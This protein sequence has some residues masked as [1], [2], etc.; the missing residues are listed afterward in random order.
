ME[1]FDGLQNG[2]K[3]DIRENGFIYVNR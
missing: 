3:L 2:D 1:D